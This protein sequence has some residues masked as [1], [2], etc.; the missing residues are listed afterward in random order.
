[1]A[2]LVKHVLGAML[3]LP[4]V[5]HAEIEQRQVVTAIT[6]AA[7]AG[8]VWMPCPYAWTQSNTRP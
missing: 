2:R 8:C 4:A 5:V 6:V 1:M 7:G 3:L